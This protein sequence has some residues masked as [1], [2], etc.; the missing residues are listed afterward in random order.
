M[1]GDLTTRRPSLRGVENSQ[2]EMSALL[3]HT[4][5]GAIASDRLNRVFELDDASIFEL[6][7]QHPHGPAGSMDF[8]F[9]MSGRWDATSNFVSIS[10]YPEYPGDL[11]GAGYVKFNQPAQGSYLVAVHFNGYQTTL[12][13]HGPWGQATAHSATTSDNA[14]VTALW[15]TDGGADLHFSFG[16]VGEGGA[17]IRSVRL[18][19]L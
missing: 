19:K 13:V 15:D 8:F 9:G 5:V 14:V 1:E 18:H 12:G 11:G 17:N 6:S 4:E 10:S 16:I 3:T 2:L 7:A